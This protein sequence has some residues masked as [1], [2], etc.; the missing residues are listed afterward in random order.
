MVM[1]IISKLSIVFK[2]SNFLSRWTGGGGRGVED[3]RWGERGGGLEV[4]GEGWRTGGGGRGWRT[5]GGGEG[6]G[7]GGVNCGGGKL[8][9][10]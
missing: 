5:G 4:G 1:F 2:S 3:W 6:W 10:N 8:A 7:T 9:Q